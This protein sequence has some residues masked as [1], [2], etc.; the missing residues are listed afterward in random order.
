MDG[1]NGGLLYMKPHNA[2]QKETQ[3][4]RLKYQYIFNAFIL[5]IDK[6]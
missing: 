2:V 5:P 3:A 4:A 1:L 6:S